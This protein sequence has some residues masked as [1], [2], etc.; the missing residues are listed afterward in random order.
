MYTKREITKTLEANYLLCY[1][2]QGDA[3]LRSVECYSAIRIYFSVT[4]ILDITTDVEP[5]RSQPDI[6]TGISSAGSLT[7]STTVSFFR[8]VARFSQE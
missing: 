2:C 7:P 5:V 3:R 8:I 1:R 6:L 4:Y